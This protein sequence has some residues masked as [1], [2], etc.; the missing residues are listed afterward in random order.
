MPSRSRTAQAR[1]EASRDLRAQFTPRGRLKRQQILDAAAKVLARRGYGG[2]QLSEIAE[3]ARTLSGSLYYHFDSREELIEEVLHEGVRLSFAR[4]RVVVDALPV[5]SSALQRLEAALRAH[6]KFQL[7]ESDYARAVVRSIGQCPED[8]W[9]R[10]NRKFRAYGK[11]FDELIATAIK[12][13]E[14]DPDVDRHA[15]RMLIIGA[16]N[17]APEWYRRGGSSS[18]EEICDLLIRL[19]RRGVGIRFDRRGNSD[20]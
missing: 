10:I 19:L 17:W 3:E 12:A 15:L 13:E 6:L 4:A 5:D 7:V 18:V 20:G 16:A 8:I 11:Y 14:I 2:A 1:V 9:V